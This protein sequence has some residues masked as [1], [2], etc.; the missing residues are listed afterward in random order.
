[1][2]KYKEYATVCQEPMPTNTI[3]SR[4]YAENYYR[5]KPCLIFLVFKLLLTGGSQPQAAC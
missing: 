4:G 2:S 3:E 5:M 1:V